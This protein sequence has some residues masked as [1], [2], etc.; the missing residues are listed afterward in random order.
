M[1][2]PPVIPPPAT[3]EVVRITVEPLLSARVCAYMGGA[4]RAA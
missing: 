3:G 1:M 2:R 4:Q